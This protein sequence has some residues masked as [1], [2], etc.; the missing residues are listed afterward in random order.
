[1]PYQLIGYD[2]TVTTTYDD[3]VSDCCAIVDELIPIAVDR[4]QR[5]LLMAISSQMRSQTAKTRPVRVRN[6]AEKY[7]AVVDGFAERIV[8]AAVDDIEYSNQRYD[9]NGNVCANV[10]LSFPQT[11]RWV[12][13]AAARGNTQA[14]W[15]MNYVASQRAP[16]IEAD[17]REGHMSTTRLLVPDGLGE[18]FGSS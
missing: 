7:Q 10:T 5:Q 1:M 13:Y 4:D 15:V 12:R 3:A 8:K 18:R 11:M 2:L 16:S 14:R 6:E 17:Q 9:S